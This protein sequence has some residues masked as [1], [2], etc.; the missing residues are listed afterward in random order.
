MQ[1]LPEAAQWEVHSTLNSPL[2]YL[3]GLQTCMTAAVCLLTGDYR[4]QNSAA[5]CTA[6]WMPRGVCAPQNLVL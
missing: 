2:G 4:L 5:D 1:L 6:L 3:S